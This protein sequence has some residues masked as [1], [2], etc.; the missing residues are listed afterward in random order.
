MICYSF[1]SLLS[2]CYLTKQFRWQYPGFN[3]VMPYHFI[4]IEML[5]LIC[6]DLISVCG[7]FICSWKAAVTD[8]LLTYQ[9]HCSVFLGRSL[10]VHD[11]QSFT[12][13][14]GAWLCLALLQWPQ[15]WIKGD[16]IRHSFSWPWLG[17]SASTQ[18]MLVQMEM[19]P[20]TNCSAGH[21]DSNKLPKPVQTLIFHA[22]AYK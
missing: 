12:K 22:Y 13:H 1:R 21:I 16:L 9:A 6:Y 19:P 8:S 5:V 11:S 7:N 20:R 10:A 15:M 3:T 17:K 4:Y 14:I 18:T 2:S